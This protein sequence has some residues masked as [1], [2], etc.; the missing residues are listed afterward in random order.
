MRLSI[1]EP[2]VIRLP[3]SLLRHWGVSP[4]RKVEARVEKGR[5]VLDPL[6]I[7]GDPFA[8]GAKK[9]DEQGFEKAMRK[10]AEE[11]AKARDAFEQALRE[12]HDIDMEKEREERERWS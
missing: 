4:G 10:E 7:E 3:E 12:K 8:D 5:L 1:E 2:G 6:P 11:K 9:P